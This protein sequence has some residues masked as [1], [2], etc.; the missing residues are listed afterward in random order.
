M[1][2]ARP[3]PLPQRPT[4]LSQLLALGVTLPMLRT[5]V[6]AGHLLRLHH[7]V[8][9]ASASWPA[10]PAHQHLFR[11]EAAA[12]AQPGSVLSH[13][14]A[15]L[16]WGLPSPGLRAWHDGPVELSITGEGGRRSGAG[17]VVH[18]R[19]R[20]PAHHLAV[21]PDGRPVTSL[22]RTTADLA[23]R[24]S[25]PEALVVLDAGLRG[26]LATMVVAP[27][28][29]DFSNPRLAAAARSLVQQCWPPRAQ[30]GLGALALADPARETPIESLSFARF[31][32]AGLPS[33]TC[34][35][36][37]RTPAGTLYPDFYWEQAQLIG[38]ADGAV[39][40]TDQ[41][42]MLQEKEREQVLRDLGF[43]IVRWLG[44]EIIARPEVVVERVRRALGETALEPPRPG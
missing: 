29:R 13:A 34:Q 19:A 7:G 10:E 27:R 39:K 28:R 2:S 22:A 8:Y 9:L 37:L 43:R 5:Q 42:A 32:L 4:S 1:K 36:A 30:L 14:S 38:E 25:L 18:R 26:L 31:H 11:A 40:Y 17:V 35:P 15:A 44:R 16:A 23:S 33:P 21:D 24:L 41:A 3:W 6:A 12:L 20:L